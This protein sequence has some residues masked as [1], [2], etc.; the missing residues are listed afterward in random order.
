MISEHCVKYHKCWWRPECNCTVHCQ[1]F[2]VYLWMDPSWPVC[3]L[4]SEHVIFHRE[5]CF[6]I[7]CKNYSF[8]YWQVVCRPQGNMVAVKLKKQTYLSFAFK[9]LSTRQRVA[10]YP[11]LNHRSSLRI[12]EEKRARDCS[13]SNC[14]R[15]ASSV[16]IKDLVELQLYKTS[17]FF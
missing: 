7:E 15:W 2:T 3:F 10:F 17:S 14:K 11:G 1:A 16:Q 9:A 12:F 5:Y 6:L 8:T 4:I 13:Q